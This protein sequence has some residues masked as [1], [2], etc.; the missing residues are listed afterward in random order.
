VQRQA[1]QTRSFAKTEH[2]LNRTEVTGTFR[3]GMARLRVGL[4]WWL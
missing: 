2:E 4:T 3:S 1:R